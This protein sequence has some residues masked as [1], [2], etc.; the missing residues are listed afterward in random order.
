MFFAP[1]LSGYVIRKQNEMYSKGVKCAEPMPQ[2]RADQPT[3]PT[4]TVAGNDLRLFTESAPLYASMIN[5]IRSAQFRV[6]L[7]T[8]IFLADAAGQAIAGALKERARAGV[9]VRVLYDAF[10]SYSTPEAFFE[11]LRQA[12]VHVHAYHSVGEA[13]RRFAFLRV[14]NRRDHRKILIVDDCAAYFGGMNIVDQSTAN[15]IAEAKASSLPTSAGWRDVHVRLVGPQQEDVA[16]AFDRLWQRTKP[17]L[18]PRWPRW[19]VREMLAETGE[20]LYLFD[21]RPGWRFRSPLRVFLPLIRLACHSITVSMAYF[22][23]DAK[24]LR[25]LYRAQRRGV[26]VRIIVPAQNDVRLVQWATR[27]IYG[28]L[29]RH[30]IEVFERREQMLHSKVMVIDGRWT[31]VGSCNLDSRS[32]RWNLEF[33]SV[34][35]SR[36]MATAIERICAFEIANSRQVRPNDHAQRG[37]WRRL[38]HRAAYTLR[39]WL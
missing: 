18:R 21:S 25:A 26:A 16:I 9:D 34:I 10:G 31:V 28:S 2:A 30:G 1:S 12:G 13:L 5:D 4:I 11:E 27:H 7:E 32:L 17:G 6:W 23:P 3:P 38:L 33:F 35:R 14:L 36:A 22:L 19:P 39:M 24:L 37:W 8:Y 20:G 29:L 15:T